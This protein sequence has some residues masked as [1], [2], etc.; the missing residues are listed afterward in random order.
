MA[1]IP[2]E[3][4][5]RPNSMSKVL[6]WAFWGFSALVYFLAALDIISKPQVVYS[7]VLQI[8]LEESGLLIITRTTNK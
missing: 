6:I 4:A 7:L 3:G 2:N 1:S 5:L 8:V